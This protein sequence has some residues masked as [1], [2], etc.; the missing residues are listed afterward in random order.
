M[1]S[2]GQPVEKHQQRNHDAN[3]NGTEENREKPYLLLM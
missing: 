3:H 1:P 2:P